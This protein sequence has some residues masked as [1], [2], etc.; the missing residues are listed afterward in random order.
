VE[1]QKKSE[2]VK[3]TYEEKHHHRAPGVNHARWNTLLQKKCFKNGN[4]NY[5]GFQKTVKN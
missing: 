2:A 1:K 5:K 4:V 3:F